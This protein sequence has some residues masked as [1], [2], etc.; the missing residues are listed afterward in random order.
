MNYVEYLLDIFTTIDPNLDN[1]WKAC[2]NFMQHLY[3]HTKRLVILKPKIEGLP[4]GHRFKP[5][6]LCELSH[7]FD[8][9]GNQAERKR[10]LVHTL[11]LCR[12]R[13]D[14]N[15]VAEV[16]YLLSDANRQ[17]D[18]SEEGIQQAKEAL[19]IYESLGSTLGQ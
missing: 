16:L 10:L 19:E 4:D 11:K 17:M 18:L 3:W 13:G 2:T 5:D 14:Q 6:C 9:I 1:V 15:R 8:T 12:E 7:L